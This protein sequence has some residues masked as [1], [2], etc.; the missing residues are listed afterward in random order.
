MKSICGNFF[1]RNVL[2]EEPLLSKFVTFIEQFEVL[3]TFNGKRFDWPFIEDRCFYYGSPIAP[4]T[5][6]I[7][8]LYFARKHWKEGLPNCKLQTLEKYLFNRTRVDDL[9]G[10]KIP[11]AYT[12]FLENS[13]HPKG[14]KEMAGAIHHNAL[15]VLTMIELVGLG[16][17][18]E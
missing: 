6:H 8:L 17:S 5:H 16:L 7:D 13:E 12:D 9:P 15:D 14:I 11:K 4:P 2:E 1:A 10:S 18:Q 3:V